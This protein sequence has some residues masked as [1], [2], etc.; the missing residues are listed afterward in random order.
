[1]SDLDNVF[2]CGVWELE[3]K[4]KLSALPPMA[5]ILARFIPQGANAFEKRYPPRQSGTL[6]LKAWAD[7]HRSRKAF[8]VARPRAYV[9]TLSRTP[10]LARLGV[11]PLSRHTPTAVVGAWRAFRSSAPQSHLKMLLCGRGAGQPPAPP[12]H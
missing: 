6:L 11:S 2:S 9:A 5:A 3:S 8:Y 10:C 12:G 1:M 7:C 4:G